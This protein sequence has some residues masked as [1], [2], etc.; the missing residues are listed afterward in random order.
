MQA[1]NQNAMTIE[2]K[3][4]VSL[5][6]VSGA[7]VLGY[8]LL[9]WDSREPI[10]FLCYS[11][12][13]LVASRLKVNL[14]GITGTMSV[15]F[16][17]IL[18]SLREFSL[19]E[20][21][22]LGCSAILM[23]CVHRDRPQPVQ[24]AFNLGAAALAIGVAYFVYRFTLVHLQ[25]GNA[26]LPL[27]V[28]A[29]TY[30]VANTVPVALVIALTEHKSLRA[31]WSE[32]Y[33]WA[34]PYY[35]L[36]GGIV[37]LVNWLKRV[38]G[39]EVALAALP[40]GYLI[41]RSYRLYLGKLA[42]EKRYAEQMAKLHLRTI[43]VL[44]LAIEAK[45]RTTHDHLQR[46]RVY[47]TEIARELKLSGDEIEAVHAASLLHDIGKLAVPEHIVSKPGRLTP[48]EFEKMKIHPVVGAELFERVEFPYPVVPIV[49][50]HHEKWDGSGYPAGLKGEEIPIGARI[51]SAVDF[52]DALASDRQYRRALP[53]DEVMARLVA[54]SNKS[55]DPRVVD[56]LRKRYLELEKLASKHSRDFANPKLST[57]IRVEKGTAPAAG[58][59]NCFQK[60]RPERSESTFLDLI[61][62]AKQEAQTFYELT[63]ELG[64]SLSLDETLTLFAARLKRLVPFDSI[65]IYI[66][67]D[68]VLV[69]EHVS[70][71]DSRLFSHLRIPIGEG[72]S[73][74]VAQSKK[75][76]LNGN[77][78]VEPGYLDDPSK[79]CSLLSALS[80]PLEGVEGVVGVISLYHGE[81]D[82]FTTDHLRVLL[83]VNAKM[84]LAIENALKYQQAECSATTDYLTGLPNAR[85]L[86]LHVDRELARAKRTG[87]SLTVMVGDLDGFKQINDRFGHLEGNRVLQLFARRIKECCREYDYV[88]RLGGDE[89][90]VI[91]PNLPAE[92]AKAK[93][94]QL[95]E[96]ARQAGLEVC[97]EQLLSLSVGIA[98]YPADAQDMD[99]LLA[100]ADRRM[101]GEKRHRSGKK[102]RRA[103]PR[104]SC[105][106]A[107]EL[108]AEGN[109]ALLVAQ[110][111]NVGLGG[112]YVKTST[113]LPMATRVNVAFSTDRGASVVEGTVVRND[114][115]A[116]V[117]IKFDDAVPGTRDTVKQILAFVEST[118]STD[119]DG[120]RYLARMHKLADL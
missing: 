117:A 102:N 40:A 7:C 104:L 76:I 37:G 59:E 96:L 35:L 17:F 44:A 73:G 45:D 52:L 41:Y 56:I 32:C 1:K 16:L 34:F 5:M 110:V 109:S 99:Q 83:A 70:G 114:P 118:V 98:N 84:A 20:T 107:V 26:S 62:A 21:L 10:K 103:Y 49:R 33:F 11:L 15:N 85:S 55:F 36:G 93:A 63:Q 87:G 48:E 65:A 81:R 119:T 100:E 8:G 78:S 79:V 50:A 42:D 18:L 86:F 6:I 77:P 108:E 54:E 19:A 60:S 101:Y 25:A 111:A 82:A 14:P 13:A 43:E 92:T 28:A 53:L 80:V 89:F 61:V 91:V 47:A 113:L 27:L 4:F 106:V 95:R 3:A 9:H 30:F 23:Q 94:T 12:V 115:G 66:Q 71:D 74:W 31:I 24:I 97:G 57:E 88:A 67:R 69:P 120:H 90:V 2:A 105:C 46:V 58:F 51:L 39:W 68:G 72:L 38:I 64:T 112:C 116:G 75:A 22:L 29:S